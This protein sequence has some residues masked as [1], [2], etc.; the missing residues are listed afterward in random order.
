VF[1]SAW[2]DSEQVPFE[3]M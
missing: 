3:V 2:P 1:K